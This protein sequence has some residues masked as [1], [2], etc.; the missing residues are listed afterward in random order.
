[1][2]VEDTWRD[3]ILKSLLQAAL[4][5][6]LGAVIGGGFNSLRRDGLPWCAKASPS[7]AGPGIPAVGVAEAWK[8]YREGRVQFIDARTP[9][10]YA[11]GHLPGALSIPEEGAAAQG[12]K[13][14][15]PEGR[16]IVIY[17]SDPACPKSARLADL[18]GRRGVK[19]LRIMPEGW[20]GWFDAG[21]PIEGRGEE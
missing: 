20:V 6:L 7:Q 16:E 14:Q 3:R 9:S 15:I 11:A 4:L 10:E 8:G 21:L 12:D 13:L 1:M 19:G 18:L 2:A 17:C 5:L